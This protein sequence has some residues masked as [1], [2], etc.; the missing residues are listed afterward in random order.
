M[1]NKLLKKRAFRYRV[2]L[3]SVAFVCIWALIGSFAWLQYTRD[4]YSK[5]RE[6]MARVD[7]AAGRIVDSWNQNSGDLIDS[8]VDFLNR[9]YEGTALGG[10]SLSVY[11][12]GTGELINSIGELTTERPLGF[13]KADVDTLRDGSTAIQFDGTRFPSGNRIF[14]YYSRVSPEKG[15]EVRAFIPYTVELDRYLTSGDWLF[16]AM[17]LV[18]GIIG[19]VFV[20]LI[21]SHQAKNISL[22]HEFAH[23]AANDRD[24]IPMGEFP[25]DEL[26]DISRQ[27]ISIYN[28][29]MQANQRREREHIIALKANE[30]KNRVKRVLTN[31]IS[32]ELKT[33]IGIIKA[34]IEMLVTQDDMPEEDRRHFLLKAQENVERITSMLNDLSTMTRL[35]E[36]GQKIP[37]KDVDFHDMVFNFAEEINATNFIGDM[38]FDFDIPVDCVVR[39]NEGLLLSV[40]NNLVKNAK[41]YSQGTR[42]GI[43]LFGKKE[44]CYTFVFYDNGTGV[45]PEHLPH[46]FD[47]FYRIDSGRSRKSGGTGLGLPIVKSAVN[48]MG[49]GISVRNRRGGGLEF[50]FTLVRV[51][52]GQQ[53][54]DA[55]RLGAGGAGAASEVSAGA[56]T[57]SSA[58]APGI[59]F[60]SDDPN[61]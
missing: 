26:G 18:V 61:N 27:I 25:S 48:S 17:I 28:S 34:Y 44:K 57:G 6:L 47:R 4:R 39:G 37:M 45:A 20:Y 23:R 33:P 60:S 54:S 21:T 53:G 36:S 56:V 24:F 30:E 38:E 15:L 12:L 9:Y 52:P 7:L 49:G 59:P 3:F 5:K 42:M 13:E 10:M 31:N 43:E 14:Y 2:K 19:T 35:E 29:R 11:N 32:H 1:F 55:G 22:L 46:L 50:L 16:W 40:L 41:A 58:A 8:Y 51:A